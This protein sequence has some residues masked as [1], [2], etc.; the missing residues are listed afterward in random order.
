MESLVARGNVVKINRFVLIFEWTTTAVTSCLLVFY[1]YGILASPEE[2][3]NSRS[4]KVLLVYSIIY[5]YLRLCYLVKTL[6]KTYVYLKDGPSEREVLPGQEFIDSIAKLQ[7][8]AE[9]MHILCVCLITHNVFPFRPC[10]PMT[11]W[12]V[13]TSL[14]I[15]SLIFVTLCILLLVV[16]TC[17]VAFII[18][19]ER[20]RNRNE[21]A[22]THYRFLP[23]VDPIRNRIIANLPITQQAPPDGEPCAICFE[24]DTETDWRLLPC[25]HRFHPSCI[26]DW[27]KKRL[28]SCPICRRD[29]VE[30]NRNVEA[31][32]GWRK[33]R[34]L[35]PAAGKKIMGER[36]RMSETVWLQTWS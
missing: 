31:G 36:R 7:P 14:H 23:L 29:P 15:A 10:V 35:L 1:W 20:R 2:M 26:D 6:S 33:M 17:M 16:S 3:Q 25:G 22:S 28:S 11:F 32:K 12:A 18:V 30:G 4:Y 34:L 5:A 19:T 8:L 13:C 21:D 9:K 27:L 24:I